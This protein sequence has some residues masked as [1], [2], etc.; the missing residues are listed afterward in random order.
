MGIPA[1]SAASTCSCCCFERF[2]V[3][4]HLLLQLRRLGLGLLQRLGLLFQLGFAVLQLLFGLIQ[5]G[6]SRLP[7]TVQL[8]LSGIQ[9]CTFALSS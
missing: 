5:L 8:G 4:I 3:G 1:A 6:L 7:L 2:A 9:A